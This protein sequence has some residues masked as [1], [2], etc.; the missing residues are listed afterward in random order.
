MVEPVLGL[1]ISSQL[2][3]LMGGE[4][5]I[6]S[7]VGKG[8]T[9]HFVSPILIRPARNDIRRSRPSTRF[10]AYGRLVV[11]DNAVSRR[12]L[13]EM[14]SWWGMEVTLA[15]SGREALILSQNAKDAGTPFPIVVVD[16]CM[17]AMDGFEVVKV[18]PK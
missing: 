8:S 13:A 6:N 2:V 4:I 3:A 7:E 18:F 10:G 15:S 16:A 11:D 14:L 1:T 5:R 9:F 12:I 17:P